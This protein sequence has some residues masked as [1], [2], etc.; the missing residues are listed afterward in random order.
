M[1]RSPSQWPGTARSSTSA[2][3]SLIMTMSGIWPRFV[4][5]GRGTGVE[6]ARCADSGP[7]PGAARRGPAR[8]GTGRSSRGDTRIIGSSGELDP[9]PLRD[10]LRRPP[11]PSATALDLGRQPRH[12]PASAILGRRA[13]SRAR[14]CARHARYVLTPAVARATSRETV[15]TCLPIPAAIAVNVSPRCNPIVISSRSAN[16]NRPGPGHHS[17]GRP[18]RTRTSRNTPTPTTTHTPAAPRSPST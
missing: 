9:Q 5:R 14:R 6:P 4:A 10:L 16:V 7:A 13:R 17:S 12:T 11:L 3:R 2:G 8:T 15:E 1:M 18:G